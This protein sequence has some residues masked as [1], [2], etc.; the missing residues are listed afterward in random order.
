RPPGPAPRGDDRD[1]P[2]LPRASVLRA[3]GRPRP[4]DGRGLGREPAA[5]ARR[6]APGAGGRGLPR[7]LRPDRA[8]RPSDPWRMGRP[9]PGGGGRRLRVRADRH[10]ATGDRARDRDAPE[11]S[12]TP[13]TEALAEAVP[14]ER[15]QVATDLCALAKPRVVL[16]VLV[17][18]MVGFYV[19]STGALDL[20]RLLHLLLGTALAAGGTLALNQYLERDV[21]ARM[22]RT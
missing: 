14:R 19:G 8:R 6:A 1:R 20:S 7:P 11:R 18:T 22:L 17:T 4:R 5:R 9:P 2:R 16:M 3:D 12:V 13:P 10:G 21:D 15:R